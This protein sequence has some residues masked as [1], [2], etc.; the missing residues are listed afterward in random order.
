LFFLI[1]YLDSGPLV[2]V[3]VIITNFNYGR[4]VGA[5]IDSVLSQTCPDVECIVVDD[6]S[7]DDSRSVIE[8][9]S[10]VRS[11]FKSNGGQAKALKA[12][13]ELARGDIII[14]LDADDYLFADACEKIVAAWKPGASCLNFRLAVSGQSFDSWPVEKFLDDGHAGF[15]GV[16]GYYPSA[17]MSGNAFDAG[18]V[19]A[20]L[21]H[22]EHLDGDGVDAYLLYSAPFFGRVDHLDEALGFYR[23]HGENVSMTSGRKTVKNLG[24]HAYYQYWAQQNARR[25]ARERG[26]AFPERSYLVGAYPCLW[27]LVARDGGYDRK[28]LPAQG[29]LRTTLVALGAFIRQPGIPL[30]S[31]AKNV[32]L[33]ATLLPL[34]LTL[35]R[36]LAAHVV[37]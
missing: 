4:F 34:P 20:F 23:T 16:Y 26:I 10:R 29:R 28:Q 14:S 6:G 5:A 7:T 18:Y 25:V 13:V 31:R 30:L 24:D 32:L 9:R 33:L 1:C 22:G 27:L 11:L 36:S 17:P 8:Q 2:L 35:R 12:G 3:S 37:L 19:R 15:L 21:A